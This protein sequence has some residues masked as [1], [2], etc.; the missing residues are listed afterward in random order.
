MASH[1]P[2][3]RR[4]WRQRTGTVAVYTAIFT[5][6]GTLSFGAILAYRRL[7]IPLADRISTNPILSVRPTMVPVWVDPVI[8]EPAALFG[9]YPIPLV[10]AI[11]LWVGSVIAVTLGAGLAWWWT[12]PNTSARLPPLSRL[13]YLVGYAFVTV[14]IVHVLAPPLR[15]LGTEV[16]EA[17]LTLLIGVPIIATL[18]WIGVTLGILAISLVSVRRGTDASLW[19][20]SLSR[21]E[22]VA[23]Y[24]GAIVVALL[25]MALGSWSTPRLAQVSWVGIAGVLGIVA[26]VVVAGRL[27]VAPVTIIRDGRGPIEAIR[28]SNTSIANSGMTTRTVLIVFWVGVFVRW[29]AHLTTVASNPVVGLALATVVGTALVGSLHALLMAYVYRDV[30]RDVTSRSSITELE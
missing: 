24:A 29:A 17:E 13:G 25:A 3:K 20:M 18:L 6:V 30:Q 10:A 28:W 23:I 27:F 5:V 4:T 15:E 22:Y 7:S 8:L 14:A 26:V 9:L 1:T 2:R 12:D 11:G 19:S 16:S 21:F